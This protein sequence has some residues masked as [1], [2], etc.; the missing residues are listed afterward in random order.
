MA[1]SWD[2]DIEDFDPLAHLAPEQKPAPKHETDEAAQQTAKPQAAEEAKA[3][4]VPSKK[5]AKKAVFAKK[6]AEIPSDVALPDPVLEKQRRQRIVEEADLK[7]A[8]D[9]FGAASKAGEIDRFIPKSAE[10]FLQLS[11]MI[12]ERVLPYYTNL[13]YTDC[14]KDLMKRIATPMRL[15]DLKA[16]SSC[17]NT[18][19]NDKI[20]EAKESEKKKKKPATKSLNRNVDIMGDEQAFAEEEEGEYDF[21]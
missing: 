19:I 21:M 2:D 11:A 16:L 8:S 15:E 4:A 18:I 7:N 13:H 3:A 17:L 9:M 12:S 20:K 10:D 5:S 14:V 1:D 6:D